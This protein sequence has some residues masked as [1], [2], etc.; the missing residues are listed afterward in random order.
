[1][2]REELEAQ[3]Q[4]IQAALDKTTD[5]VK[6]FAEETKTELKNVGEISQAT[7]AKA[8][9]ALAAQGELRAELKVIQQAFA[10]LEAKANEEPQRDLSP[11]ETVVQSEAFKAFDMGRGGNA[12]FSVK[13]KNL[14]MMSPMAKL[15]EGGG[16]SGGVLIVPQRVPGI[17]APPN[18]RLTIRDLLSWGRTTV[19]SVEFVRESGFTN[20]ADVVSENPAAGK[21]ESNLTFELDSAKVATIA[22]WMQASKQVLADVPQLQAYID[23]RLRYGLALKEETQLLKGSGVGL[24]IDGIY[25]QATAYANPGVSVQHMTRVDVLRLAILQAELAEYSADGIVLNPVDWCAIELTKD[26]NN[27]YILANPFGNI[28]PTLWARPVVST[29]SMTA[30]DF[31]VG[32]FKQ[33]AQGWD[34]EDANVTVSLEDRDNFIKNMVTILAEERLALTVYRPEAFVKGAFE[35]AEGTS[36]EI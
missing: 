20:N 4:Q 7:K 10:K 23:G 6:R 2:T 30:D 18:M 13:M 3:R 19:D 21:P 22:H 5:Q 15:L 27:N 29:K 24:N 32:A 26:A 9:E 8:D 31:L 1:M 11:G 25:T 34:R 36:S 12:K 14:A 28:I 35:T 33:G 17:V 16:A